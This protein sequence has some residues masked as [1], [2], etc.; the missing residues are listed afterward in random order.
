[1]SLTDSWSEP[2]EPRSA[3]LWPGLLAPRAFLPSIRSQ[4][5]IALPGREGATPASG[6]G[7]EFEGIHP[8]KL[9]HEVARLQLCS[10]FAGTATGPSGSKS[11]GRKSSRVQ[12]MGPEQH[13]R[14]RNRGG[15]GLGWVLAQARVHQN[16]SVITHLWV[17]HARAGM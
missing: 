12:G 4:A 5:L 8:W 13:V 15:V 1:M 11:V 6:R 17:P 3:G 16:S 10:A 14:G 9:I 2:L 7:V